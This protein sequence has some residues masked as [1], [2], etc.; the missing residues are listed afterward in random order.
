MCAIISTPV[1]GSLLMMDPDDGSVGSKGIV[2]LTWHLS[3]PCAM[4]SHQR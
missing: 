4:D 2:T 1:S 3:K